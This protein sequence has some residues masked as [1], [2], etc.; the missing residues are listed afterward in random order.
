MNQPP[1]FVAPSIDELQPLFPAYKLE[2][3]L[4]QGG[5]GAVYKATQISLDRSVAIKILPREFGANESFHQAFRSEAKAMA[6]LNHPALIGVYDFGEIGGMLFLV[7]EF[8]GGGSLHNACHDEFIS[9]QRAGQ[10]VG[11]IC[12][13]LANAHEGGVLHRDIKPANI[14]LA[15]D[16]APKI[17]DFG[18]ARRIGERTEDGESI[19][20]TPGYAAPEVIHAGVIDQRSDIFSVGALL[21]RLLTGQEPDSGFLPVASGLCDCPPLFDSVISKATH[22]DPALRYDSAAEMAKDLEGMSSRAARGAATK[23]QM[24]TGAAPASRPVLAQRKSPAG[25]IAAIATLLIVVGAIAFFVTRPPAVVAVEPEPEETEVKKPAPPK[26]AFPKKVRKEPSPVPVPVPENA[27]PKETTT[28]ALARL[29]AQ[30]RA[31]QRDEFPPGTL[32]RNESH[33]LIV[34]QPMTWNKANQFAEA[35][36]AHL[37]VLP[38]QENRAWIRKKSKS[39]QL[40]WLGAGTAANNVW[41]WVDST[42][43]T[44][45]ES[46][47]PDPAQNHFVAL[48]PTN[49]LVPTPST[50]TNRFALQ[51]RDDGTNPGTTEAQLLRMGSNEGA[52]QADDITY[53]VG[54]RTLG[55]SHLLPAHKSMTWDEAKALA[56]STGGYLAVPS[57]TQEHAWICSTFAEALHDGATLW[58]GGYQPSAGKRW[59]WLTKERWNNAGWQPT[60]LDPNKSGMR[61]ALQ[62][63]AQGNPPH[64]VPFTAF[65][66]M[67]DGALIEWSEPKEPVIV[68]PFALKQWLD[69]V[70]KIFAGRV[71]SELDEYGEKRNELV[72]DYS[73]KMTRLVRKTQQDVEAA[74]FA[75]RGGGRGGFGGG[76]GGGQ[77]IR[78]LEGLQDSIKKAKQ[79][80]ELLQSLPIGIPNNIRKQHA[81]SQE[82][83]KLLNET[84]D[85]KLKEQLEIYLKGLAKRSLDLIERGN[86]DLARDLEKFTAPLKDN[87]GAFAKALF[88]DSPSGT[89]PWSPANP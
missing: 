31:G 21:H 68:P 69:D 25:A 32:A 40:L 36:G 19:Y 37:A 1:S 49:K 57:S 34:D 70:N 3:F 80:D 73:R 4:A 39:T 88:P 33:Y 24:A 72:L 46:F 79:E 77:I 54:T 43:W 38:A 52:D 75:R 60:Q 67:A 10:I 41:Q 15:E 16:G 42:P 58:L 64:W 29:K 17:G 45:P 27:A 44:Q 26:S 61:L 74:L 71:G 65:D 7:M 63:G 85:Q 6:R 78:A 83:L 14:L 35:H 12:R 5:M 50:K 8:V 89:L 62:A 47:P 9:P 20:G 76:F 84:Y 13:G 59:Q 2:E 48:S 55:T 23:L 51:W 86:I 81:E 82:A 30:L 22:A 18:L 87:V 28:A 56:E 53:P 11:A 66:T